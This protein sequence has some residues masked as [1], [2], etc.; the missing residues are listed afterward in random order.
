M[1]R[2]LVL[3]IALLLASAGTAHAAGRAVVV[4]EVTSNVVRTEIDVRAIMRDAAERELATMPVGRAST[5]RPVI[6]SVRLASLE[7]SASSST[8]SVTIALRRARGGALFAMLEGSARI[9]DPTFAGQKVAVGAAVKSALS[10][11]GTALAN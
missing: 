10:R 11:L 3:S 6:A 2:R 1:L 8:C 9:D 7:I 4:G 5:A